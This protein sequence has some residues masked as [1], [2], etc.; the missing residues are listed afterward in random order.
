MT[1]GHP[2]SRCAR[3]QLTQTFAQGLTPLPSLREARASR[4]FEAMPKAPSDGLRSGGHAHLLVRVSDIGLQRVGSDPQIVGDRVIPETL[5]YA[6]EHLH[7]APAETK[8]VAPRRRSLARL[9][10]S[11]LK[12]VRRPAL[13]TS[14]VATTTRRTV[15]QSMQARAADVRD[16]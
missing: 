14:P 5:G 3:S 15:P 13:V 12:V 9:L 6:G 7:F 1:K 16:T 11:D 2:R 4:W 8:F 10:S